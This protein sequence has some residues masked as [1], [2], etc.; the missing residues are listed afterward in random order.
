MGQRIPFSSTTGIPSTICVVSG[1]SILGGGPARHVTN[2][3]KAA[4]CFKHYTVLH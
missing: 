1:A 3:T 2:H 4:F